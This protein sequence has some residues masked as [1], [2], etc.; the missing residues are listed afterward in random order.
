MAHVHYKNNIC[1]ITPHIRSSRR[2]YCI[3]EPPVQI[4]FSSLSNRKPGIKSMLDV[5][6][7]NASGRRVVFVI[8]GRLSDSE[9]KTSDGGVIIAGENICERSFLENIRERSASGRC[10]KPEHNPSIYQVL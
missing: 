6:D 5:N 8:N 9:T 4:Q 2:R 10:I 1:H 3:L 7:L